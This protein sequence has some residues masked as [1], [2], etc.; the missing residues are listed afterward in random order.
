MQ[1]SLL[2]ICVA[3]SQYTIRALWK[4]VLPPGGALHMY[5]ALRLFIPHL[6]NAC[7]S[8][9]PIVLLVKKLSSFIA[10]ASDKNVK[11]LHVYY[12]RPK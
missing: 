12:F 6:W 1:P 2:Y 8:T 4:F 11:P 5:M 9:S 3:L 10:M 7:N